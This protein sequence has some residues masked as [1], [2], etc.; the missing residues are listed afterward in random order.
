LSLSFGTE[1]EREKERKREREREREREKERENIFISRPNSACSVRALAC[2][3][4]IIFREN[5][6]MWTLNAMNFIVMH[7]YS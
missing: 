5:P 4:T 2:R 1:R 6:P 3:V 7:I